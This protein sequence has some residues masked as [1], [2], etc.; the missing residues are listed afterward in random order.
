VRASENH[1]AGTKHRPTPE[2]GVEMGAAMRRKDYGRSRDGGL[3]DQAGDSSHLLHRLAHAA[4]GFRACRLGWEGY[5]EARFFDG[6]LRSRDDGR[7][8]APKRRVARPRRG[9]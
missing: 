1:Y 2:A 7:Q 3:D 4:D 5:R 6:P 8:A 9:A